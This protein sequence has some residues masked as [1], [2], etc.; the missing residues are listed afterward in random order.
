M[1]LP[2][3]RK[4]DHV[5]GESAV[6]STV[7]AAGKQTKKNASRAGCMALSGFGRGCH[8]GIDASKSRRDFF[9]WIVAAGSAAIGALLMIPGAGYVLDPVLRSAGKKERWIRVA[10]LASLNKEHPVSAAVIGEQVDAWTKAPAVRLGTVWLRVMQDDKVAAWNAECPHLG[11]KVSFDP[12]HVRF[13][14]P[15]HDSAFSLDGQ[16]TGG[17]APRPMDALEARVQDGHVEVRFQRFRAQIKE[18]IEVG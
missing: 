15:C 11:C 4:S 1:G 16:V 12:E 10:E 6:L 2:F 14:C 17:P 8:M 3:S 18:Q 5:S 7:R 13:G 9:T